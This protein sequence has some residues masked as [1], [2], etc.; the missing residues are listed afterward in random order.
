M[1][2]IFIGNLDIRITEDAI[3]SLFAPHGRVESVRLVIDRDTGR[4][5]GCAFVEM[6]DA[7]Q[8]EQAIAELHG[9]PC[10]GRALTVREAHPRV[11]SGGTHRR[12]S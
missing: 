2:N 11:V 1:K 12:R 6:G 4:S 10:E 8:A 5:R 7:D 3:R 9:S